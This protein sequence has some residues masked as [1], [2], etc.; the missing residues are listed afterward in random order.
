MAVLV[1]LHVM[2]WAPAASPAQGQRSLPAVGPRQWQGRTRALTVLGDR[3]GERMPARRWGRDLGSLRPWA[4]VTC[5]D[6]AA[7]IPVLVT[8]GDTVETRM[9]VTCG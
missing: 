6:L 1:Q 8:R 4:L 5:G 9:L 2:P 7:E 3:H